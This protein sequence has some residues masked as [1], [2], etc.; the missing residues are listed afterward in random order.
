MPPGADAERP[1]TTK[2]PGMAPPTPP[3]APNAAAAAPARPEAQEADDT[4]EAR[5]DIPPA[6]PVADTPDAELDFGE[7]AGE[8]L[9]ASGEE[10]GRPRGL[11][12][13][14]LKWIFILALCGGL[15]YAISQVVRNPD[16]IVDAV[17]GLPEPIPSAARLVRDLVTTAPGGK[18]PDPGAEAPRKE[19]SDRLPQDQAPAVR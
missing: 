15:G 10:P 6:G 2:A 4:L 3:A 13:R 7:L 16:G 8:G 1:A 18:A 14:L 5:Q 17:S 9:P 19:K 11:I 12:P